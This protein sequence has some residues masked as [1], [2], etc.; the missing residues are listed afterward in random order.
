MPDD[1]TISYEEWVKTVP[2]RIQADPLWQ[3]AYYRLAMFF[4][5]LVWKDCEQLNRDF[6]GREIVHQ[7]IR[8]AGGICANLEEAYGRGIGT[9]D[10]V[11]ILRIALGEARETQG[12]YYRSRHLLS[13]EVWEIRLKVID[14][15]IALII[16]AINT[17][18]KN[19]KKGSNPN[20]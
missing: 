11:R 6:R 8:S 14:Q 5:D 13:P 3:S 10:Y 2:K 15:V 7:L 19:I 9:P 18:R 4:Y 20:S 1:L 16:N 12:W 17:Q